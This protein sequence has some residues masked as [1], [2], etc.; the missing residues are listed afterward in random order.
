MYKDPSFLC[1]AMYVAFSSWGTTITCS[2]ITISFHSATIMT[3]IKA[4][5]IQTSLEMEVG[6][7]TIRDQPIQSVDTIPD[8]FKS[9]NNILLGNPDLKVMVLQNCWGQFE[10]H[11]YSE[12]SCMGRG[13]V[14]F[15]AETITDVHIAIS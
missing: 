2:S 3:A 8:T 7:S 14:Y 10:W 11:R 5:A 6:A 15:A 12:H 13:V 9:A 4:S 1:E